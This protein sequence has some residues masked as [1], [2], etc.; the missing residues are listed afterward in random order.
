MRRMKATGVI[1]LIW[2][3]VGAVRPAFADP[4][5]EGYYHGHMNGWGMGLMGLGM[6]ILFWGGLPRLSS[7]RSAGSATRTRRRASAT[8]WTC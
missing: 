7:L 8:H 6:M 4:L 3:A 1:A 2:I 5:A